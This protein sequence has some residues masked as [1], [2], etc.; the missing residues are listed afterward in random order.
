MFTPKGEF[1]YFK[2]FI[3]GSGKILSKDGVR[4]V[5]DENKRY[6][7]HEEGTP[8]KTDE[9]ILEIIKVSE[10]FIESLGPKI[11]DK[12]DVIRFK[13]ALEDAREAYDQYVM[14]REQN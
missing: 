10:L 7:N 13:Q 11:E 14:R 8:L 6:P 3:G 5:E 4:S 12:S 1:T 2:Y 9:L